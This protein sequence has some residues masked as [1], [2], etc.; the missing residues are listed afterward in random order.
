MIAG[1]LTVIALLVIRL[2]A[3]PMPILPDA[4]ILPDGTRPIAF[5]RGPDWL[6]VTTDTTI[7]IYALDGTLKQTVVIE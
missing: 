4:I 5:T 6:A 3:D 1:V 2:Q 7:L